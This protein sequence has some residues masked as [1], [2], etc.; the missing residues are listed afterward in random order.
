VSE[1]LEATNSAILQTS[2]GPVRVAA[3][4]S[5]GAGWPGTDLAKLPELHQE[6]ADHLRRRHPDAFGYQLSLLV[7]PLER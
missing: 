5:C 7:T 2:S 4:C 1:E 3:V 6:L